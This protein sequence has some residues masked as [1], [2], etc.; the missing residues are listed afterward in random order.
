MVTNGT[1]VGWS[2]HRNR[3]DL[4]H[5]GNLVIVFNSPQDASEYKLSFH[6][7][8]KALGRGV[9]T[10]IAAGS[11]GSMPKI[12][13]YLTPGFPRSRWGTHVCRTLQAFQE[14]DDLQRG[15]DKGIHSGSLSQVNWETRKQ[16]RRDLEQ[17]RTLFALFRQSFGKILQDS[18]RQD[19]IASAA[20]HCR[21]F[22]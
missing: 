11:D 17:L 5:T 13:G 12:Q 3:R 1:I 4:L 16:D 14:V 10:V 8:R 15:Y 6:E 20:L 19:T 9:A 18:L 21:T 22:S 2:L 7:D